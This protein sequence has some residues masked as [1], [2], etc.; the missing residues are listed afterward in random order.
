MAR[1]IVGLK[2]GAS[3]LTAAHVVSNGSARLEQVAQA[4]LP[5]G[6][7]SGGEVRD[8]EQLAVVVRDF[9]ERT[10]L[11]KRAVRIGVASNRIGVRTVELDGVTDPKQLGNAIRFRA[12]E[13]LPIPLDEAVLD[14]Q[15]LS[16]GV[17]EDGTQTHRV[18]FVVAYRDLIDGFARACAAAGVKLIG[19]DLEAFALLRSL[20]PLAPPAPEAERGA[21]VAVSIG[22]ERST[23]AVSDGLSCEFTRVLDWGGAALTD[24]LA[25]DLGIEYADAD[26]L[27]AS[28]GL[29]GPLPEGLAPEVA[30][31]AR[32]TLALGV[33]N[34]ARELVASLQFYQSQP[35]SLGIGEVLLAGGTARLAGF[36][37]A[38]E[39]MV[40]VAVRVGDPFVNLDVSKRLRDAAPDPSLA[41]PIGLGLGV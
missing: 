30:G 2:I 39:R 12:Q 26:R 9:F 36:A 21:V 27:K 28:L 31:R 1:E 38:L 7:V 3:Q 18:Q 14:Y 13:A 32:E 34:F 11:P 22:S 23:L 33:Q 37:G 8:P 17:A 19:I 15:V 20:G 25:R 41:V 24:V 40:G 35:G 16:V 6:I 5:P 29:E 4:P 10:K